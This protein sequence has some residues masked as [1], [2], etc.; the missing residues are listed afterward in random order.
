MLSLNET[1][2]TYD[3]AQPLEAEAG[4][5]EVTTPTGDKFQVV[6]RPGRSITNIR[7]APEHHA[8]PQPWRVKKI[9]ELR[10]E[11]EVLT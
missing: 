6:C 10:S 5:F 11:Q 7:Y 3:P 8:K 2:I 9:A 4:V 1:L